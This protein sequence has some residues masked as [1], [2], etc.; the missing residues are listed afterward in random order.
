[1][2]RGGLKVIE[3]SQGHTVNN[4]QSG[5]LNSGNLSTKS[6]CLWSKPEHLSDKHV[7]QCC[8]NLALCNMA[9]GHRNE[10]TG[11]S[12]QE[13]VA[14]HESENRIEVSVTTKTGWI[15]YYK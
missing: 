1:M 3:F 15:W 6:M 2:K 8:L 13:L 9:E 10:M 14:D 4:G 7:P 5:D 12:G 11:I